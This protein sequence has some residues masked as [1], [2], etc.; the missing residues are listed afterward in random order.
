MLFCQQRAALWQL[1]LEAMHFTA[2]P[3]M[4]VGIGSETVAQMGFSPTLNLGL[5]LE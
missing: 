5:L 2:L 4:S 3:V 1:S